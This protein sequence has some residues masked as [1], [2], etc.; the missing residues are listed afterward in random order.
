MI[1]G[2][3]IVTVAK[4]IYGDKV[5]PHSHAELSELWK[6]V[7]IWTDPQR[8]KDKQILFVLPTKD[9]LIDT[10]E[11]LAEI[12]LQNKAGNTLQLVQ[13]HAFGHVG[14]IIEETIIFPGRV[15]RYIDRVTNL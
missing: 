10:S 13:R 4:N 5:W 15:M 3:N 9:R 1:T 6:D 11:V 12:A 2:G 14:T 7:N 8:L